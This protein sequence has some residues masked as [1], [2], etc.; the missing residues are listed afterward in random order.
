MKRANMT[1]FSRCKRACTIFLLSCAA[2]LPSPAQVFK[3]LANFEGSDGEIPMEALTQGV[4]GS[5][6]GTTNDGSDN[7]GTVFKLT[8]AGALT[9]VYSFCTSPGCPDGSHPSGLILGKDGNFYGTT[10][11]GGP[12]ENGTVFKITHA[13]TLTTLYSF[14]ANPPTCPDGALPRAPLI[15]ANDGNFY[16]TT[17]IG[18]QGCRSAGGCGTVFKISPAGV[19][20]TLHRFTA[21]EGAY[22]T[23]GMIEA[24]NEKFYGTAYQGGANCG[25]SGGCGTIFEMTGSGALKTLYSFCVRTNCSDGNGPTSL[26][27]ASDGSYYGTTLTGG[28]RCSQYMTP[29]GTVFRITSTGKLTTLHGFNL[30]DGANPNG[31]IIQATD[32]LFYGTTWY[33]GNM[34]ACPDSGCGTIYRMTARGAVRTLHSFQNTD[35]AVPFAGLLQ[36]TNGVFYGNTN[37]GGDPS[38]VDF[39]GHGCG[40]VFDLIVGLRPFVAFVLNSGRVRH[41]VGILGQGFTGTI[42]VSFNGT[43]AKF[44]VRRDAFLTATV[45]RGATTGYVTVTTP[46]GKLTSNVRFNVLP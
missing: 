46:S 14:C 17:T 37:A 29:C 43:P 24:R 12:N 22:P 2:T 6:Y 30:T 41:M 4:D 45:P 18:G 1:G 28:V 3:S 44:T 7:D 16:G 33:G 25:A 27:Q 31:A 9:T 36:A 23:G 11:G 5:L 8:R 21:L 34:S 19:L 13:G 10:Y 32:G 40:T 26:I 15:L 20:T 38:C 39:Q 42:S 35:G